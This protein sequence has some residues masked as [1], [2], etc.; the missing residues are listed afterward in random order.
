LVQESVAGALSRLSVVNIGVFR[1]RDAVR[2]GVTRNQL[3]AAIEAGVVERILPDTYRMTAAQASDE[4]RLRG[5]LLWAGE[6]AAA[7]GR[8]AG[9]S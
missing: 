8:S 5:A 7:A 3:T 1:G 2:R 6:T 4:Q 9:A